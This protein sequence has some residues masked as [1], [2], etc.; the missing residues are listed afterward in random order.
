MSIPVPPEPPDLS[1][2]RETVV[3]DLRGNDLVIEVPE[4]LR[5]L[6]L[7][8]Q[9]AALVGPDEAPGLAAAVLLDR[10]QRVLRTLPYRFAALKAALVRHDAFA[11]HVAFPERPPLPFA[12]RVA[13]TPR[14]YQ[15][16]ALV[17]WRAEGC[18]GVVVLPTGSGKTLLGALAIAETGVWALVVVP[19]IDLLAQWRRA[20]AQALTLPEDEIGVVGGGARDV[21]PITI[22]TYES[23]ALYPRLLNRFGLVVFDECHHLPAPSYRPIAE[24]AFAP[25]RLGL[26]A[27]PERADQEHLALDHLIGPE[28]YRREPE[29]LANDRYLAAYDVERLPIALAPADRARYDRARAIYTGFIRQRHLAIRSPQDFQRKVLWASARDPEA[30][31]AMVAWREA[32]ALALNAPAKLAMLEDL[33]ARHRDERVLVFSEYNMLVEEM[34]RRCRIPC[35]THKTPADERRA[36]LER[37][38]EGRYTKLASGRVLNEGVDIPDCRVAIIVSG[39]A[40][41]REYV[42]RLGRILRPKVA[43]AILYELVTEETTEEAVADRRGGRRGMKDVKE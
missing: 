17:A 10:R 32:R 16:E 35:V 43:R 22:I 9:C 7:A 15:E 5:A 11:L 31:A 14:P 23:A 19:T 24:G 37:F 13:L 40:T 38:R 4:R 21:R 1:P 29:Q 12:P 42:Q 28:V 8:A 25:P 27:T 3:L 34:S 6:P 2:D 26:S 33:F 18:R 20:L 39:N 36:I 41:R 30:R